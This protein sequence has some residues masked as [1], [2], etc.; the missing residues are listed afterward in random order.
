MINPIKMRAYKV[1]S[2][3]AFG[4]LGSAISCVRNSKFGLTYE[5]GRLIKPVIGRIMVFENLPNAEYFRNFN[6]NRSQSQIWEVDAFGNEVLHN[7]SFTGQA[8]EMF[9]KFWAG[10][11]ISTKAAPKGTIGC[12]SLRLVKEII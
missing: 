8:N 6:L 9:A 12:K 5:T 11:N 10:D 3:D 2:L 4:V 1:F 7:V